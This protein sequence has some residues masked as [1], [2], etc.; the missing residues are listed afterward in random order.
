MENSTKKAESTTKATT[1]ATKAT[2][3]AT[4]AGASTAQKAIIWGSSAVVGL[5]LA[6]YL[7]VCAVAQS[8]QVILSNVMID[9]ISVGGMT[10]EEAIQ[11]VTSALSSKIQGTPVTL[12]QGGWNGVLQGDIALPEVEDAVAIALTVG[13]DS[14]FSSGANYLAGISGDSATITVPLALNA[15]GQSKLH[16]LLDEADGTMNGGVVQSTWEVDAE[17]GNLWVTKGISGEAVN[18]QEAETA[19]LTALSTGSAT[20]VSLRTNVS[21]PRDLDFQ[22]VRDEIF[23]Q[24]VNAQ[25]DKDTLEITDHVLGVDLDIAQ[26]T[27]LY[28]QAAEGEVFPIPLTI[29][30][31]EE[32]TNDVR[33]YLFADVLA[34]SSTRVG[35]SSA[36]LTNLR[37]SSEFCNNTILMPGDVFSY[38]EKCM[39]YTYENGYKGAIAIVDGQSVNDIGGG[40]CQGSSTIYHA[41]LQTNLEVVERRNHSVAVTYLPKG[42]DAT[43]YGT[44]TDFKF[45]NNTPYPIKLL[46]VTRIENGAQYYDVTLMGTKTDDGYIVPKSTVNANGSASLTRYH[47]DGAGNLIETEYMYTDTYRSS[48]SGSTS[49]PVQQD[50]AESEDEAPETGLEVPAP[51]SGGESD[52]NT[53]GESGGD[54]GGS[55]GGSTETPA[56]E[57]TPGGSEGSSP[58]T[59]PEP[60]TPT[61]QPETPAPETPAPET[62]APE[63]EAPAPE[64]SVPSEPAPEPVVPDAQVG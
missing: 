52:G 27:Q 43:V 58:D 39:P 21:A 59:T 42:M 1:T 15:D 6:A 37:L 2:T 3:T 47:Y 5:T 57:I 20:K 46:T 8:S 53:G 24:P 17:G 22:A 50:D 12:V 45:K 33:A 23:T 32:T 14:F 36:R 60:E 31:P 48:T 11:T 29:T 56:P 41:V 4:K 49:E 55:S 28:S 9:D 34:T 40:V 64:P 10:R 44:Y 63:P 26:A 16:S 30:Q 13:R 25:I 7:G 61:P 54:S 19:T 62:P 51:E 18:R 38:Q 35:G